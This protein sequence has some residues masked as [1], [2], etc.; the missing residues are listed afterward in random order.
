MSA[1]KSS[2]VISW[3]CL[4]TILHSLS[5][6]MEM[7][8]S[9]GCDDDSSAILIVH[10]FTKRNRDIIVGQ[11]GIVVSLSFLLAGT[12][13]RRRIVRVVGQRSSCDESNAS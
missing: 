1:S 2:V 10:G 7:G 6:E 11:G 5:M 12:G 4:N 8:F 9:S 13:R 3:D